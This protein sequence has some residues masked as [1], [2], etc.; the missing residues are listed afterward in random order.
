M[1]V[2]APVALLR[3]GAQARSRTRTAARQSRRRAAPP[4]P[5]LLRM[6]FRFL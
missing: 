5:R 1:A 4:R 6:T 2:A 3:R